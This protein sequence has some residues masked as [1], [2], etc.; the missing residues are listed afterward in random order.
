MIAIR[1][2]ILTLGR[3]TYYIEERRQGKRMK[4]V[5][6]VSNNVGVDTYLD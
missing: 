3:E 2:I 1:E 6:L 4:L 5:T